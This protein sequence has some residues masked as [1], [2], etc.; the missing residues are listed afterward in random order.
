[1][2]ANN[3]QHEL[4]LISLAELAHLDG[5]YMYRNRRGFGRRIHIRKRVLML[6]ILQLT[7]E[8]ANSFSHQKPQTLMCTSGDAASGHCSSAANESAQ[9][10][11]FFDQNA[12][13]T[14]SAATSGNKWCFSVFVMFDYKCNFYLLI[15]LLTYSFIA[16][17]NCDSNTEWSEYKK[18][19]KGHISF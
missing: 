11:L 19:N 6:L 8:R 18:L 9:F 16:Q 3:G 15:Y 14:N 12:A 10:L 4:F 1:M 5:S 7:R 2:L 13:R 17:A